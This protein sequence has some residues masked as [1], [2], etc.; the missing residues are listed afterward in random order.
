MRI[1]WSGESEPM[2]G[3]YVVEEPESLLRGY[4]CVG[5]EET[6]KRGLYGL[7][8]ERLTWEDFSAARERGDPWWGFVR[9]RK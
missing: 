7:V 6:S 8:L 1:R 2:L 3:D 5:V 9:D 4:R